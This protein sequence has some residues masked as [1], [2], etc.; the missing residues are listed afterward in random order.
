M[1]NKNTKNE[2]KTFRVETEDRYGRF[3]EYDIQT[4]NLEL[5][6][7]IADKRA[8]LPNGAFVTDIKEVET[9]EEKR[10]GGKFK[11]AA[12]AIKVNSL[13]GNVVSVKLGSL[14]NEW[15]TAA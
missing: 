8:N 13:F 4:E 6:T 11:D 9:K 14:R 5:A 15:R 2:M 7:L 10:A 3:N 1:M 12:E